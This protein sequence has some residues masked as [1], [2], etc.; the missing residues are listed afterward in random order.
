M[1]VM[2]RKIFPRMMFAFSNLFTAEVYILECP[3]LDLEVSIIGLGDVRM[4]VISLDL[5]SKEPVC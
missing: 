1:F 4:T 2:E 3:A 5:Q